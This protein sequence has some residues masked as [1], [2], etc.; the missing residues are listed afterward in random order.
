VR[1]A[2][3]QP[4]QVPAR[5]HPGRVAGAGWCNRSGAAVDWHSAVVSASVSK[6]RRRGMSLKRA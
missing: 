1:Q 2:W 5:H 4:S 3:S 6:R